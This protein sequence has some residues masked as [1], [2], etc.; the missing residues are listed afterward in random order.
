MAP[1]EAGIGDTSD[2]GEIDWQFSSMLQI[3]VL[4]ILFNHKD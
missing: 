2:K 1:E 3:E 4:E